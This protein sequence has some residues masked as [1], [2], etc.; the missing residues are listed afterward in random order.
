MNKRFNL[1]DENWILLRDKKCNIHEVSLSEAIINS[2]NY[3]SMSGELPTQDVAIMRVMLAVLHTIFSRY[4]IKGNSIHLEDEDDAF[5]QWKSIW[6]NG[7]FPAEVIK[8]YFEDW[9]DR[10]WLIHP[11]R[12]FWQVAD[13]NRGT[14]YTAAKLNGELAESNNKIRL[15][16][17]VSSDEKASMSFARA[18]RWLINLNAYDDTSSKPTKEGSAK[19]KLPSPGAGWLGKIG[20]T[21]LKGM[22]LFETLMFNLVMIHGEHISSDEHP[23][24]EKPNVSDEERVEIPCPNNFAE[25]YTIQSRRIKLK[26][27]GDKV[28]GCILIGGDFFQKENSFIEP[29][30]IWNPPRKGNDAYSPRRHDISRHLWREFSTF[31]P[32]DEKSTAGIIL[33]NQRYVA[34]VLKKSR[35][36]TTAI[37][38]VQYGDKDFFVDNIYADEM[39]MS[40]GILSD[41]GKSWRKRI[42][43]EIEKCEETAKKLYSFAINVN[44]ANGGDVEDKQPGISAKDRLYYRLDIPFKKWITSINPDNDDEIII[45]LEE[46]KSTVKSIVFELAEDISKASSP[47]AMLGRY[48]GLNNKTLYSVPKSENI[49]RAGFNSIYKSI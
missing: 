33:W 11:K 2:Q 45:K 42:I 24:W 35:L 41:V 47:Q 1:I 49:L 9:Y 46:W 44:I 14:E 3:V 10:F 31:Y 32:D 34:R 26:V 8:K 7:C 12:P 5:E 19:G 6:E 18:A 4:D 15:F 36:M 40:I 43:T 30:T 20:I 27:E 25:L 22:N 38:S 37:A 21:Y 23:V 16:P 13:L 48:I 28:T 17:K 39:S 29:M